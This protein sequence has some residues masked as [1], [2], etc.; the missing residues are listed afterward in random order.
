M[1]NRCLTPISF[2][3]EFYPEAEMKDDVISIN[4]PNEFYMPPVTFRSKPT[5]DVR[6]V[7]TSGTAQFTATEHRV[8]EINESRRVYRDF[9]NDAMDVVIGRHSHCLLE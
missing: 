6:H 4:V 2:L 8:I 5:K 9:L 3:Q 7:D 1:P